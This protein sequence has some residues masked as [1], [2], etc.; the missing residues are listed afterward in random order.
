MS[1]RLECFEC[2]QLVTPQ[3]EE[4]LETLPVKGEPTEVLAR[5]GICPECG[6][7]MSV[8]EFDE[9]TL[10]TAFNTYRERHGLMTPAEMRRLRE[11]Y[12]LGQRAFAL[13]LGWGEIT[14]HRFESG[15]IQDAAHDAQLK[16]A[17]EPANV[18]ILV[19]ANG[20]KL[21]MRQR[22][23]LEAHLQALEAGRYADCTPG[24]QD[25]FVV[26]EE[27]DVYGG[28]RVMA[29][30]KLR[31][32]MVIFSQQPR[33]YPTKLNKL[34]FYAD[35]RF[36]REHGVSISGS[37]YLAY[38]YG[39]VPEHYEWIRADLIEGGDL[40][41]A[42]VYGD[43][44]QGEVLSAARTPDLTIFSAEEIAVINRV[45][46]ELAGLTAG[47][48]AARSHKERAWIETPIKAKISYEWACELKD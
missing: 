2:D 10:V 28:W 26:R 25:A 6:A 43:L 36:Y 18:R 42:E 45:A 34:L 9:A 3:V 8:P 48:L 46:T 40:A 16:M 15:S 30:A 22:A 33:M 47:A 37:P 7:D 29:L 24:L 19:T 20:H 21:T 13:L 38:Q 41:A 14:L 17:E 12:G 1:E 39:P 31:E 27:Q 44:W 35:F 5:V 32:M 4:R 11:R 23:R